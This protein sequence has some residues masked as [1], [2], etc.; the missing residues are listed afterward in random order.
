MYTPNNLSYMYLDYKTFVI[1]WIT[2][3]P[4]EKDRPFNVTG[5]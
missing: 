3:T 1:R 5:L 4:A 2:R